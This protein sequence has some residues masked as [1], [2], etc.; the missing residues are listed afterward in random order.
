M[1]DRPERAPAAP[2]PE[3]AALL[4]AVRHAASAPDVVAEA[5]RVL[6]ERCGALLAGAAA[7]EGEMARLVERY[8]LIGR[9]T[10]DTLWEWD[11][12]GPGEWSEGIRTTF[13]WTDAR[14]EE[15]WWLER[16]HPDDRERVQARKARIL[17]GGDDSWTE[18]YRFRRA[19]GT[20]ATVLDRVAVARGPDGRPRRMA[21]AISDVSARA[22]AEE[23]LQ[24][25]ELQFRTLAETMAAATFIYQGTRFAYVNRAGVELTGYGMDELRGMNF[26]E[27]VHP[28][29]RDAVRERGMAR[30]QGV[31]VPERYEFK[32]VTKAGRERWVDFTAGA[33]TYEGVP[34]ALGTAFDITRHKEA[35]EALR[36]QALTFENLYDAVIISDLEGR[37]TAWNPA[38]ERIYGYA[39]REALGRTAHLWLRPGESDALDRSI[40]AALD[41][42]GRWQGEIHFVRKDGSPGTSETVVVPLRD[43]FGSRIGALGVNRDITERRRAE[44]ALRTSEER[45][46]LMVEGSEQVFFYV[47]DPDGVFRYL[48]PSIREVM[49]WSADELT[50]Q[51]YH[52]LLSGDPE[53]DGEVDEHT[54]ETLT[55][56]E[57]LSTY[58]AV[59]RHRDGR[60]VV[61]ELVETT[62]LRDGEVAGVQGF[63]RDITERRRAEE[64]MRESEERYRTLF[65]ESRDA[66]YMTTVDGTFLDANQA[67]LD[68]FGYTRDE[69]LGMDARTIY[70]HATDRER[71]Q[72]EITRTGFVRDYEVRLVRRDGTTVD[73]LLG[74]TV[75]RSPA[76]RILGYQGI[77][78]D[79]T[80]R[81]RAEE[82]LA[83]GALHDALTGLP[84]R[85]LF[86]DRLGHAIDRVKRA[87]EP[88]FAVLFLD[89]DRFKVIND[90]LGHT[91]GDELL[92]AIAG[93]LE[94]SLRPG[95]TVARFG[96]D[97]FTL[98]LD[99]ISSPV[100][101]SHIAERVLQA[102]SSPFPLERHEVFTSASVGIALSSSGYSDPEELLRNADAALSRAKALGK[103]RY[104]VFDRAM[105]AEA[106]GRLQMETDLR[107]AV[108]R[109]EFALFYQ[110]II[111]LG[112]GRIAGFEAL[113]R[114]NHPERGTISPVEF[115]PVAEETGMIL[116]IGR[117][118]VEEACR[119]ARE[120]RRLP[121]RRPLSVGIN[122]SARQFAQPDLVDHLEAA[123]R[124][125]GIPPSMLKVEITESVILEDASHIRVALGR[126][127]ALGV[128]LHIDDFGTGYS[129]LG[130]LHRFQ[131]DALKIDRSFVTRMDKE[132][133]QRKLVKAIVALARHL[134]VEVVA[135]GI[136]S[137][138]QLAALREL[139]CE[140]GQGYL[141]SRPVPYAEADE[142]LAR[143]PRW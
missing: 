31:S 53:T 11:A 20:Y 112:D 1:S 16:V 57:G 100:E 120:W 131:V 64:A 8:R 128:E 106:M 59:C 133:R 60:T 43:D 29:H 21:G 36:R 67:A 137:P 2:P 136:D 129:S 141:F 50:G 46:R 123:L 49:G 3:V 41:R 6:A 72:D 40:I 48:S 115:I 126:L 74:A 12:D 76:G 42:E 88:A 65:E 116:P 105:H 99:D 35:E 23:A 37:I 114:W 103:A 34:A 96:G 125:H 95:D 130:Y 102:L 82:Q 93:R 89:L 69:L 138:A 143:D 78:H 139:H 45:Y 92:V 132:P 13:G 38:A 24:R 122:L 39:A 87:G 83:Y 104:E 66:I 30:Q 86:V 10:N 55:S 9:A 119:Q 121:G 85:A 81:K 56:R 17:A 19:D 58:H 97:E 63:A 70:L 71:F 113:L 108:E 18:Q 109:G 33:V 118:V 68:L 61:L 110:P 142:M 62:L 54:H 135:E 107:R 22:G 26:W 28:D 4:E 84:N 80:E 52:V 124:A 91:V 5:A 111:A 117:W 101:A 98:L 25:S 77:I 127:R 90:S 32:I 79:I 47:H 75:R 140:F 15:A 44:E 14:A 94:R 73:C 51:P 27:V 134:E 7:R